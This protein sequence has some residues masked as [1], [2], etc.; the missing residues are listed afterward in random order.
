[1]KIYL[2][3]LN[4]I[5]LN[6]ITQSGFKIIAFYVLRCVYFP[7]LECKIILYDYVID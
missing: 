5:F 6:D 3:H 2:N 1:M 7:R 4:Q